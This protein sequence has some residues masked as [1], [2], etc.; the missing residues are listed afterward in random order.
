VIQKPFDQI[1]KSDIEALVT[2]KVEEG[3][4]IEYKQALP[5]NQDKDK[6][7]FLADVSSFANASGGDL[8]YGV[9]E[10]RDSDDKHNGI[11]KDAPG[12]AILNADAEI[13]RLE[14]IL[15]DGI[16]PRIAGVHL[17]TVDG[18]ASG[19]MLLIRIQ[20]SYA[21]PHMVT[22]QEHSRFYSR[23]SKGK[24]PL[25]VG[26]IRSAFALSESLTQRIR[27]FRANRVAAVLAGE[28][29]TPLP[30][31]SKVILHVLPLQA[32]DPFNAPLVA[33]DLQRPL[34]PLYSPDGA[35]KRYNFDGVLYYDWEGHRL[36]THSYVQLFRTGAIEA[37]DSKLLISP[38]TH[39]MAIQTRRLEWNLVERLGK[40]MKAL[41]EY[42]VGTPLVVMVTLLGVRHH[43]I[44]HNDD[45]RDA[46]D[47]DNLFL[48]DFLIEDYDED[49]ATKLRPAF[50]AL[51]QA[52]GWEGS[53]NYDD[54]RKWGGAR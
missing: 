7:E 18:F 3:R 45:V 17:R 30:Q 50:D 54:K 31:G 53:L 22:F 48:P 47:R 44:W 26:E 36:N 41:K 28:T 4:T 51:W 49:P 23:N 25:D 10:E 32:L 9:E 5:G 43:L 35:D 6:K 1:D 38:K 52:A 24:Y 8:L 29:P 14:N 37:V 20:K 40:Y 2:E 13:R 11:P 39:D 21:A 15:R 42:G 27:E 46:I 34:L 33:V 16:R 19:P 12:L